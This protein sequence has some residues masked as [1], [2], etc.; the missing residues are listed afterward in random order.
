M[1][2]MYRWWLA[3]G[4]RALGFGL[5]AVLL[6]S[7]LASAGPSGA[8]PSV[9]PP[10]F[11]TPAAPGGPAPSARHGTRRALVRERAVTARLGV[12]SR[13][14]GSPA[15][16]VGQRVGLNLFPDASF[17]MTVTDVTRHLGGGRT[18][19]GTLDG[20]D[21]GSAVLA[22]QDGALVGHVVMPGAVYRV[23]HAPD[24]TQVV[25]EIDQAALP[26]EAHPLA[27]GPPSA[28]DDLKLGGEDVA[29]DSAAQI[30]VMVLYTA[31]ARAA[32][33]GT[34]AMQA[35]VNL[36]V[37]SAN[38]AYQHNDL[39]Q[40]LRLVFSGEVSV[41]EQADFGDDLDALDEN[42]MVAWLRN[43]TRADLVSLITNHGPASPFCGIGFLMRANSTSFAPRAFSVVEQD[44]AVSNL[45][46]VHELGH[47][48]GAHHD[49]YVAVGEST[50]FPYSHGYVDLVGHFRT[51][52]A[53]P[54][55]C[56]DFG[57]FCTRI[58]FFSTPGQTHGGRVIGIAAT[59]DNERTLGQTANAVANFR[60]ALTSP[61]TLTTGVT[62][63]EFAVGETL[64]TSVRLT[65]P[66]M[67][68]TADIYLG[69][70]LP[71]GT[72]AFFTD[73]IVTPDG[74]YAFGDILQLDTYQPIATGVSLASPF[75]ADF[76]TFVS[77]QRNGSE[78]GGGF[79]W[80][81]LVVTS[82]ALL[83]GVL[84]TNELL[85]A[86]LTPFTFP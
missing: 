74:G 21:L 83:D 14:D 45:T 84:A 27:P 71:D 47:N 52:M 85:G 72:A 38:L 33:G 1:M 65:N 34:A 12:L 67:P 68:G 56:I 59:A 10:L 86:S 25:E 3:R 32:A 11:D 26:P 40:R 9:A 5:V 69:L 58:P 62:K 18:W 66:G 64:V 44:C 79:A 81:L 15:L 28:A 17:S 37:A 50:I 35:Q 42:R 75:D 70:L 16:G 46:F 61:L 30:D 22:V 53:Y 41:T 24:G 39:V 31:A 43:A 8:A 63:S 13:P 82:G 80:F 55:Q 51:I 54:D 19:S 76:P 36:A 23:G 7:L 78:P 49:A 20:I 73:V 48:M 4:S 57:P 60:R 29:A 77:Y 6:V 2:P